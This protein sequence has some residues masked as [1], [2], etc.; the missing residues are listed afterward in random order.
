MVTVAVRFSRGRGAWALHIDAGSESET[1]V[2]QERATSSANRLELAAA[3]ELTQRAE[4]LPAPLEVR[5]G[6]YLRRGVLE[7]LPSWQRSGWRTAGGDPVK[8][9]DLWERLEARLRQLESSGRSISFARADGG[10][11]QVRELKAA[12]R[13]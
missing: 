13:G 5:C 2:S 12:L 3:L 7:W 11:P 4:R 10:S 9:R 1:V 6:D 8:N